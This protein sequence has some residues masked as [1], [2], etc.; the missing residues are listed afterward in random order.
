MKSKDR[1]GWAAMIFSTGVGDVFGA[2]RGSRRLHWTREAARQE[3]EGWL[4]EMSAG[5]IKWEDV[6]DGTAIG[7]T[8][9]YRV[10]IRSIGFPLGP[11]PDPD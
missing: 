3:A 2:V 6:D 9:G 11:P 10:V 5:P 4:D 8:R 1:C 7:R